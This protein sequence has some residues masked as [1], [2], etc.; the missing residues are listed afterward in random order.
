LLLLLLLSLPTLPWLGRQ[1]DLLL[2]TLLLLLL[3]LLVVGIVLL[4]MPLVIKSQV[5]CN[6]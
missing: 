5:L 6:A 3:L 4:W 1:T 2:H